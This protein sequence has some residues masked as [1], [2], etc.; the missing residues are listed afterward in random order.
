MSRFIATNVK[1]LAMW[2]HLKNVC[3]QPMLNKDKHFI[4]YLEA[5]YDSV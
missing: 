5:H 4:D 1:A 2:R 3:P